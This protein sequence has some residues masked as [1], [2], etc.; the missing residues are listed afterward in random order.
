MSEVRMQTIG[1]DESHTATSVGMMPFPAVEAQLRTL[2]EQ[3]GKD[4][5]VQIY[6]GIGGDV[7]IRRECDEGPFLQIKTNAIPQWLETEH[8][9]IEEPVTPPTGNTYAVYQAPPRRAEFLLYLFLSPADRE[10]M[11]GDLYEEF[12]EII[13]PRFGPRRARFWYWMQVARSIRWVFPGKLTRI[14]RWAVFAQAASALWRK[15]TA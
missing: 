13:L 15:Y 4:G 6:R 12:N 3:L 2:L 1:I 5:K 8:V 11:P 10:A 7:F 14:L 9:S